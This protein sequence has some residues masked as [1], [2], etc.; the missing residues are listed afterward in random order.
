MQQ[1]VHGEMEVVNMLLVM[2][3]IMLSEAVSLD[4]RLILRVDDVKKLNLIDIN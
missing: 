1:L 2:L 3:N 4:I